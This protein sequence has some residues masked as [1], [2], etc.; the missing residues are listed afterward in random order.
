MNQ[1]EE[2]LG[3][4]FQ[5]L[6]A[7][8]PQSA[9]ADVGLTLQNAF[10]QHHVRRRRRRRLITAGALGACLVVAAVLLSKSRSSGLQQKQPSLATKQESTLPPR[11]SK[12]IV[13]VPEN[14]SEEHTSE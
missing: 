4:A 6:A 7:E 10:R 14:R 9:A 5:A 11:E 2:R 13:S 12:P 3:Q 8:S 1:S